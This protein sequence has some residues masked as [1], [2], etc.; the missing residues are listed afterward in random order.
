MSTY[1]L[2]LLYIYITTIVSRQFKHINQDIY[3]TSNLVK[4]YEMFIFRKRY[5]SEYVYNRKN[6]S[7]KNFLSKQGKEKER[8]LYP[9]YKLSIY[10][11]LQ[12]ILKNLLNYFKIVN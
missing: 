10:Y 3:L 4:K 7:N 11:F 9:K 12:L 8:A 2:L 5:T 1:I 6:I